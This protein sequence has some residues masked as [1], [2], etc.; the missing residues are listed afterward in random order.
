MDRIAGKVVD[1]YLSTEIGASTR[2]QSE[3]EQAVDVVEQLASAE[4]LEIKPIIWFTLADAPET[5][6]PHGLL[7]CG[8]CRTRYE[9]GDYT[10]KIGFGV[11]SDWM[12]ARR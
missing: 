11:F 1:C 3:F 2:R 5:H 4:R 8:E 6:G 9:V 12:E 7:R 10:P